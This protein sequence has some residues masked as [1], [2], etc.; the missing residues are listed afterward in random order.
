MAINTLIDTWTIKDGK[1]LVYQGDD[2]TWAFIE[3]G[4]N[5]L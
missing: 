5:F 3:R 1:I 2:E 4:V